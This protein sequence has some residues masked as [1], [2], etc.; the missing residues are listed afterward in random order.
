MPP[1][2]PTL[3]VLAARA[4][5]GGRSRTGIDRYGPKGPRAPTR[6][7]HKTV[8]ED[9]VSFESGRRQLSSDPDGRTRTHSSRHR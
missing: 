2:G 3:V 7:A 6:Q 5:P 1:A 4:V 8:T 9:H